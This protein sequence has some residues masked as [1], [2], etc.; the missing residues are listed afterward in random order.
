[1]QIAWKWSVER[2]SKV[3]QQVIKQ[4]RYQLSISLK[5]QNLL[6]S[7]IVKNRICWFRASHC[8]SSLC[9]GLRQLLSLRKRIPLNVNKRWAKAWCAIHLLEPLKATAGQESLLNF[10]AWN[11]KRW[12]F[13]PPPLNDR[14]EGKSTG[15]TWEERACAQPSASQK[16]EFNS[17]LLRTEPRVSLSEIWWHF[18]L[19]VNGNTCFH[20]WVER[21]C[22]VCSALALPAWLFAEKKQLKLPFN[23]GLFGSE[24]LFKTREPY[25]INEHYCQ[26]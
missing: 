2:K 6:S 9:P 21:W 20:P 7:Y 13:L 19:L 17:S 16:G 5:K 4:S 26:D 22:F 10:W 12:P 14:L 11:G 23:Y 24:E 8:P 15:V 1:M 25:H 3:R 18:C